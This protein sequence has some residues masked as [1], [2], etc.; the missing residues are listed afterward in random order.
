MRACGRDDCLNH[1]RSK[2]LNCWEHDGGG[3]P[4]GGC[5]LY[6]SAQGLMRTFNPGC[7]RNARGRWVS[8]RAV[9]YR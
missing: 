2:P 5:G 6:A 4:E 9:V 7:H 8:G 3:R 1:D